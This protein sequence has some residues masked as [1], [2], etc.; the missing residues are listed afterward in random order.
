MR[1]QLAQF[2]DHRSLAYT[3]RTGEHGEAGGHDGEPTRARPFP[4]R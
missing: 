4:F 2:G 1:H 3:G